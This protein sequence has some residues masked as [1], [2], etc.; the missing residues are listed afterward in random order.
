[1]RA[2]TYCFPR[3]GHL[4]NGAFERLGRHKKHG[5]SFYGAKSHVN[6]GAKHKL[7]RQYDVTVN[8]MGL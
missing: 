1:L 3:L 2:L 6:A 8:S 5:K 7:I 4:D